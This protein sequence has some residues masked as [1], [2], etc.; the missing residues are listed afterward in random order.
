VK[1]SDK[2]RAVAV[3]KAARGPSGGSRIDRPVS[4]AILLDLSVEHSIQIQYEAHL[5]RFA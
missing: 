5:S 2:R 3:W 1:F 4:S